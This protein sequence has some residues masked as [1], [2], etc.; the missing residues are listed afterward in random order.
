[1]PHPRISPRPLS[2]AGRLR[3]AL[4]G[5]TA[6]LLL[7]GAALIGGA[8]P[9][10][11]A[12]V[13][14]CTPWGFTSLQNDTYA[15]Q[16]N[17]WNST[18][19]QCASIDT[20]T[21]AWTVTSAN[22]NLPTNGAP[23]TYPSTFKGCHWGTCT[24]GSGLPIKVSDLGSATTSW[25]TTQVASGVYDVAMDIWFNSTPV[26]ADQP[27]GTEV[28]VWMNR[29]GGVQPIGSRTATVS[30]GGLTWDVWT[31][32]GASG[33][34]VVS[35]VLQNGA[36]SFTDLN[37][38]A[39]FDD[40]VA[41]GQINPAHYLIDAEAGFEIW[42][43]GQGLASNSFS[44]SASSRSTGGD[45]QAP[46]VPA[47]LT[48]TGT[49]P[50]G[51]S[52]SWA[53]A[54]DNTGVTGYD[55]FRGGTQV[56]TVSGTT[57][58]DSGLT[59][60]TAYSYTVRA[61]DAAGNVSAQSSPVTATTRPGS[62]GGGGSLKAQYKNN[63]SSAGDSQIKPGLQLVNT[64]TAAVDLS[65]VTVRYWFTGE[66][67]SSS[68]STW[69]DWA[70]IGCNRLTQKV[71]ALSGARPGADRYLEVGFTAGS[72][73]AAGASTGEAQL[74]LNKSDWSNFSEADDYS[75]STTASFADAPKITVYLD[76]QL[77]YGIEP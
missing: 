16:Q 68:Y 77:A 26:A 37:L 2:L 38:K 25:S 10:A 47:G 12:T 23:A 3:G 76:G 65:R 57:F 52:L 1:M 63:D 71:T 46:T 27:D 45:T 60:S 48:V 29:R 20:T 7:A 33:W 74:R 51:A 17:E 28:M 34:K 56:G 55:V 50:S 53:A 59:A 18:A 15:Y 35:Y 24:S 6:A 39:L 49:T 36:T 5:A 61:H 40:S 4:A 62:T 75:R 42:Q 32:P 8:A 64:S 30:L 31:G 14:D 22:F 19:Q 11:A 43:G 44:F 69:C 9:A 21:G 58:T 13:S 66:S 72:S 73:L 70:A 54:T 41:R 67:G